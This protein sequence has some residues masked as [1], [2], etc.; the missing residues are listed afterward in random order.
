LYHT[1]DME[2]D[3]ARAGWYRGNG[4]GATSP[5]GQKEANAFGLHD[6]HGNV[7]E[8][9]EDDWHDSYVAAPTNGRAWV[10]NPRLSYHVWRGG[11]WY[12]A[13]GACRSA[14]R[15]GPQPIPRYCI[16]GFRV[17]LVSSTTP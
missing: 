10:E 8:W 13:P 7:L 5:V 17:V 6:T 9:C 12:F 1:G 11:S 3:L 14:A 2:A 15:G 16:A 4:T